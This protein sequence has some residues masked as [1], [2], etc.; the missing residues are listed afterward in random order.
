MNQTAPQIMQPSHGWKI[1]QWAAAETAELLRIERLKMTLRCFDGTARTLAT[2][3]YGE[4][5]G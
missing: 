2:L 4:I 3:I 5:R 1:E